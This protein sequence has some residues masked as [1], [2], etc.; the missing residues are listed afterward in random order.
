MTR[1]IISLVKLDFISYLHYNAMALPV[2]IIFI[3]QVFNK[4]FDKKKL[5]I[6]TFI[7]LF[8]NI[9][10]YLFELLY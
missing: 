7:V 10:I 8:I 4:Y 1:A 9:F 2:L 3:C 6:I 5:N